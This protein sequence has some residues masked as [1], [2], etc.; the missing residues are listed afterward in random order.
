M[1]RDVES[2]INKWK[3]RSCSLDCQRKWVNALFQV[4]FFLLF[5]FTF[6][7]TASDS[8]EKSICMLIRFVSS[9]LNSIIPVTMV[10]RAYKL[11]ISARGA[12]L[13]IFTS[14]I[15]RAWI[16]TECSSVCALGAWGSVFS[17]RSTCIWQMCSR[18]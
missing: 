12:I 10:H 4:P 8:I 3:S 13:Y 1:N 7:W 14:M 17:Q 9:L 15:S 5:F 6:P 2:T 18:F 11:D 16:I